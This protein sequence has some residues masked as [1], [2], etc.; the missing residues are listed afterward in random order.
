MSERPTA[1]VVSAH[2]ADFV[3]RAAGAIA[4]HAARGY[5]VTIVCLS[6]GERGESAKLWKQGGITLDEVKTARHG[7]AQAA[8]A[9]VD[10]ADL[11]TFDL[12]DYPLNIDQAAV[13][14]LADVFR[15]V[16]PRFDITRMLDR[17]QNQATGPQSAE[18]IAASHL[19]A[20]TI[21]SE[22]TVHW[23]AEMVDLVHY[24]NAHTDS[25]IV[26]YYRSSNVVYI[27]G[28]LNYPMY[29][30][31]SGVS[32]FL[33]G[34]D[35]V[36]A[37]TNENTKIIPWR[38]PVVGRT[39]VQEWRN[40]LAEVSERIAAL[41]ALGKDLEEILAA[42]PSHDF[43]AKWGGQRAPERFVQDIFAALENSSQQNQR[44]DFAA[45]NKPKI[46]NASLALNKIQGK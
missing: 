3:W 15:Q 17:L 45:C 8:A 27:G 6:Y 16:Q 1:L 30:G 39:E 2:A 40:V 5:D 18:V 34:L 36:L 22:M 11:I 31:I 10:A 21:K 41:M 19:P 25:D 4:L 9:A 42:E 32:G 43:D 23:D 35:Q 26:M 7:E 33:E 20:L 46:F 13:E 24:P 12:G 44:L 38:G 28:L 37:A 14:R 29:A